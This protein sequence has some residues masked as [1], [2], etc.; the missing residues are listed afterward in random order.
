MAA[1]SPDRG[2]AWGVPARVIGAFAGTEEIG[3][4]ALRLPRRFAPRNDSF[5]SA[6]RNTEYLHCG[7]GMPVPYSRSIEVPAQ[8]DRVV[9]RYGFYCGAW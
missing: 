4:P 2:R 8:A 5:G 1:P 3:V 9:R 7:G 6:W